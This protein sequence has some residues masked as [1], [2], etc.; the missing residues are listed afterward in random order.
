MLNRGVREDS[1]DGAFR[2]LSDPTRRRIVERLSEGAASVSDVAAGLP[3]TLPA[4]HQHLQILA[5][6]GLMTWEKQG[7]VRWCRLDASRMREVEHWVLAR[8]LAWQ[9]RLDAL[10]EHLRDEPT[11]GRARDERAKRRP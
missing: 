11:K 5:A 9:R 7:R 3:M 8:R 10:G 6:S 4:V 1:L 2:A